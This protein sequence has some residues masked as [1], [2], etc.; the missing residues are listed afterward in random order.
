LKHIEDRELG[1]IKVF[2]LPIKF[3]YDA[4]MMFALSP[5][6]RLGEHTEKILLE[7]GYSHAEISRLEQ[8]GVI[9][10]SKG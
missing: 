9:R 4:D 1:T 7:I 5:P 2:G 8:G 10:C 6:P 3:H